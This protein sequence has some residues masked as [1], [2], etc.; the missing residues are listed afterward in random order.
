[1]DGWISLRNTFNIL[2]PSQL[3]WWL[4]ASILLFNE[5]GDE[6]GR[7]HEAKS[8]TLDLPLSYLNIVI[9]YIHSVGVFGELR[10]GGTGSGCIV[11]IKLLLLKIGSEHIGRRV[12]LLLLL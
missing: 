9:L 2:N 4:A 11:I 10:D 12:Q 1:M 6:G 3:R 7:Y 8:F 5:A